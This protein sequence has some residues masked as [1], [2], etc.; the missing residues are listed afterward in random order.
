M[1]K[2]AGKT[3]AKK[4]SKLEKERMKPLF[5]A[6]F[7]VIVVSIA[8]VLVVRAFLTAQSDMLVNP[9]AGM[10]YTNINID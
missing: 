5:F 2:I 4:W 7:G 8:G 1:K 3:N 6:L 9:F 10:T